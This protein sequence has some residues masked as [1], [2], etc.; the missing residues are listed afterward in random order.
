MILNSKFDVLR[1]WPREGAL[2]E[3]F[4][5]KVTG[6]VAVSLP[7]GTVVKVQTNGTDVDKASSPDLSS[8]NAAAVWVV[9]EGND[10]YSGTF[11]GKVVCLRANAMFKL[12]PA[13]IA[14]GSY[15]PGAALSFD[16]G[17]WTVAAAND[18]V[19][20]E[21]IE[22]NTAVDG[23]ITVYYHGGAIKKV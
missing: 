18:Q 13:N 8:E 2:D 6:G 10:D 19:I 1:G 23:T 22:D 7:P 16:A 21:V 9:V 11:T 17:Q 3:A 12:D 15:T 5:A 14:A 4:I 20:G